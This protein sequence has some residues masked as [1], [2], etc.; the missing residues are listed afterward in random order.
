[1]WDEALMNDYRGW[2]RSVSYDR[3]RLIFCD[4]PQL[5]RALAE[6]AIGAPRDML[7]GA[8]PAAAFLE[9]IPAAGRVLHVIGGADQYVLTDLG[10]MY[11]PISEAN[12]LAPGSV[13]FRA[14]A[15]IGAGHVRPVSMHEG[16]VYAVANR[17][18]LIAIVPTGQTAFPYRTA[19]ISEF[20]ADLFTGIRALA[21][22][23]GGGAESEQ[24]LWVA[25]DDGTALVGKFDSSNEWVGFVPVT[26]DGLVKWISSLGGDVRFNVQYQD[27]DSELDWAM[28][29]LDEDQF[30]DCAVPLNK[31][32]A[33][34]RPDP[35]DLT[36]GR[37]WFLA[38]LV[39]DLMDGD[40]HLGARTVDENGDIVTV[41]GDDFSGDD[42][43]AGFGWT[44]TVEPWL[45]S[46]P[47]GEERGQRMRRRRV[48]RAAA[49]IVD[50]TTLVFMG[51]TF[52]GAAAASDTYRAPGEG[53]SFT[54]AITLS[55]TVPGPLTILELAGEITN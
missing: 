47:E 19:A 4:F 23:T 48:K 8:E 52:G 37:L 16:V 21:A 2:P 9:L 39:V 42:V 11:I 34:L 33:T 41:E 32:L 10:V 30:V 36:K 54:P 55:K 51:R 22:M 45:P 3:S 38:G 29:Q 20:H 26:G 44:V 31:T 43:I 40:E 49:T 12:P 24:Y 50:S 35:E 13:A 46:P 1:V 5:P 6:S 25:Q 18:S 14:I 7:I 15:A 28:E 27:D 53:R 17:K